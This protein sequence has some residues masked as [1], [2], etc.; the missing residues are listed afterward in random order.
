MLESGF[1]I[2]DM[3]NFDPGE[4]CWVKNKMAIFFCLQETIIGTWTA[5][6]VGQVQSERIRG[7][8]KNIGTSTI[9]TPRG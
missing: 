3:R 8:K 5:E 6:R 4:D 7:Y 9:G 1:G 2:L